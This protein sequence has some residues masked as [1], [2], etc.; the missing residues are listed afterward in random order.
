M[1]EIMKKIENIRLK[2][3]TNWKKKKKMT[4]IWENQIEYL[5][6]K[7]DHWNKLKIKTSASNSDR[8]SFYYTKSSNFHKLYR[9]RCKI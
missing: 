9:E 7:Y 2:Q 4:L 5:G 3:N 6:R 1:T 8:I